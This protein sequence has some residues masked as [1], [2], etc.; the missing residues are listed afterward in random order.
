MG[1]SGRQTVA[2]RWPCDSGRSQ[3]SHTIVAP[4]RHGP[5]LA[6]P[7][8]VQLTG[9]QVGVWGHQ[10]R[11]DPA[12]LLNRQC[13]Q[14]AVVTVTGDFRRVPPW[15]ETAKQPADELSRLLLG[16]EIARP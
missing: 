13:R 9:R 11:G 14:K 1:G 15:C 10:R 6:R 2:L 3:N 5:G 4:H 12:P 16:P 8:R 7:H